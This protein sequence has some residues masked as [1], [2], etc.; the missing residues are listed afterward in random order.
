MKFSYGANITALVFCSRAERKY[1]GFLQNC[2]FFPIHRY[3]SHSCS[4]EQRNSARDLSVQSLF[5][6]NNFLQLAKERSQNIENSWE[7]TP[8]AYIV[9]N[10]QSTTNVQSKICFKSAK[11]SNNNDQAFDIFPMDGKKGF[12]T[13]NILFQITLS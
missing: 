8:C 12:N 3:P 10:D 13:V 9:Q 1:R 6:A 4:S 5:L 11:R 7:K 2:V